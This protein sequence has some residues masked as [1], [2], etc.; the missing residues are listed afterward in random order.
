MPRESMTHKRERAL[1]VCKR[2][3]ELYPN[4]EC[5]LHF[6]DPFSLV[7]AVLLSAQTTDATVNKVTPILFDRWPDSAA[8]AARLSARSRRCCIRW[9]FSA[10]RQSTPWR[11]H[12]W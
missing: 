8:L 12:R 6:H 11:R 3:A 2:M 4:A 1:E 7:I 10:R 5:A 9:A